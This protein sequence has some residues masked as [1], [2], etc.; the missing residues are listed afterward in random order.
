MS[1]SSEEKVLS[2]T[3]QSPETHDR[4]IAFDPLQKHRSNLTDSVTTIGFL[5]RK[6]MLG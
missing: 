2:L 1:T 4:A 3:S 6:R 5:R